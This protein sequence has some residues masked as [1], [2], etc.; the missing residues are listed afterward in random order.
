MRNTRHRAAFPGPATVG[1]PYVS[2][3]HPHHRVRPAFE[4]MN[5]H[6]PMTRVGQL[7]SVAAVVLLPLATHAQTVPTRTLA[8]P[9]AELD[10]PFTTITS[11]RELRDGRVIV[12][13]AREK[14]VQL[15]DF[16][17]QQLAPIGREGAGPGEYGSVGRLY[18]LAGDV[19]LMYDFAN[20][21]FLQLGADGKPTTTRRSDNGPYGMN[22]T[23]VG[24]DST[25]RVYLRVRPP[26][27]REEG[28]VQTIVRYDAATKRVDTI[29]T[30]TLP[31]GKRSG[32][33]IL[34]GGMLKTFTNLPFAP[35]DVVAV[36][37]DGRVGVARVADY[38]V[39]WFAGGKRIAGKPTPFEAVRVTAAEKRAFLE[40]QVRPGSFTVRGPAGGQAAP[41]SR[42]AAG[43]PKAA[44]SPEA[45]D[46]T[47]MEWP[48][49]KPPFPANA[50]SIDHE[51]RLWIRRTSTH[52]DKSPRYDVFDASGGLALRVVLPPGSVL[53]GFGRRAVYVSRA[54]E[55]DLRYLQRHAMP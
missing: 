25:G 8:K 29:T 31:T 21:R 7:L 12:V 11:V 10:E 42:D 13:D 28:G 38:H 15:V 43:L 47:G 49:R 36:G 27:S 16:T 1:E 24:I 53:V 20:D 6:V 34:G 35:E 26:G 5:E 46:D 3:Q 23:M 4:S 55:D 52:E 45:L 41:Q 48:A 17:R 22:A 19:T 37:A 30:I 50:A 2:H 14:T 18:A 44:L 54:D 51:G 32:A 39:E 40:S 9:V 33:M